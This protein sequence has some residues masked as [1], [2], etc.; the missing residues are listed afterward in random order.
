VRPI[1]VTT[2]LELVAL[3]LAELEA[4][5]A[6]APEV[7]GARIPPDWPHATPGEAAALEFFTLRLRED[8]EL[9]PWR[10]RLMVASATR[11][12][13]GHIGFHDPPEDGRLELGYTVLAAHRRNGFA[14][15][16]MIGMMNAAVTDHDVHR[17]RV[18]IS[19][20]NA[21][22]L[23]LAARLGFV[24]AGEQLDDVDGPELLFERTWP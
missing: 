6:G 24:A 12:M 15:E 8:P 1:V 3:G 16:A 21:A 18:A 19:P 17:F 22:S 4:L 9:A 5:S 11:A 14:A 10:I 20:G 23:A 13:V 7:A 2:R